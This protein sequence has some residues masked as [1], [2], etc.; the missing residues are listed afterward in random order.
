MYFFVQVAAAR[1]CRVVFGI[2][3]LPAAPLRPWTGAWIMG[4]TAQHS[5][6]LYRIFLGD[7]PPGFFLEIMFRTV[8]MYLYVLL[9]L[10]LLGKRGMGQLSPFEF[11]IIIALGL[12]GRRS[13]VLSGGPAAALPRGGHAGGRDDALRHLSLEPVGSW[14]RTSSKG[15]P[16]VSSR[17]AS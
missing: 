5:F 16:A 4:E 13:D 8:V 3:M 12:G 17:T 11:T 10:R 2:E 9:L 6:D 14:W 7:Q 1:N 15:S